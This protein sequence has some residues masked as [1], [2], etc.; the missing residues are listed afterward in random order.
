MSRK[1]NNNNE[2]PKDKLKTALVVSSGVVAI[3]IIIG[4]YGYYAGIQ[5]G[6]KGESAKVPIISVKQLKG[7]SKDIKGVSIH[8][9]NGQIIKVEN[10]KIIFSAQVQQADGSQAI[11]EVAALVESDTELYKLDLTSPPTPQN[12]NTN[13]TNIS[14]SDF[15]TGDQIIVQSKNGL[16]NNLEVVAKTIN[17][18]I[19][20]SS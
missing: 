6:Q 18:L 11:N 15:N 4:L 2:V 5:K 16:N 10:G 8:S 13:K 20:P 12:P 19:T 9:I 7:A 14:F 3:V 1:N 17:L